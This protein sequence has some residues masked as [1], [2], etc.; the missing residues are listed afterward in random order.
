MATSKYGN[1]IFLSP[2]I[3][4]AFYKK[5]L[6]ENKWYYK[7]TFLLENYKCNAKPQRV[8]NFAYILIA[9]TPPPP[10]YST[11]RNLKTPPPPLVAYVLFECPL[12]D[13]DIWAN[14]AIL[15]QLENVVKNIYPEGGTFAGM[16]GHIPFLLKDN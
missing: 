7:I 2:R 5:L 9:Q 16:L 11:V 6:S 14:R 12:S 8:I 15:G 13:F 3:G 4:L 1:V 10:L